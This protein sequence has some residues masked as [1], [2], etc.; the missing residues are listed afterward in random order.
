MTDRETQ[1]LQYATRPDVVAQHSGTDPIQLHVV[2]RQSH[3]AGGGLAGEPVA[4]LH[5]GDCKAEDSKPCV[6]R[7][8]VRL[9]RGQAKTDGPD[10]HG[11]SARLDT[12]EEAGTACELSD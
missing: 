8:A 11:R 1:T 10:E 4:L 6:R 9:I 5:R 3:D 12:H 2:E 7:P